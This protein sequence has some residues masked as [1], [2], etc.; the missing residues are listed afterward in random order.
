VTDKIPVSPE[1]HHVLYTRILM[2]VHVNEK[3]EDMEDTGTSRAR[4]ERG[5]ST[6]G[7]GLSSAKEAAKATLADAHS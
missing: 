2:K 6:L 1:P 3:S 7:G 5:K 4:D